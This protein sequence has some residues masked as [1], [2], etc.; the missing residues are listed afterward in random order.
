MAYR[1]TLM[2]QGVS[3]CRGTLMWKGV[4]AGGEYPGDYLFSALPFVRCPAERL[5]IFITIF[6][7][8]K[9]LACDAIVLAFAGLGAA[10]G[11]GGRARDCQYSVSLRFS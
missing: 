9:R 6:L 4:P 1:G 10:L 8:D 3:A 7:V 5:V 11:R 2:W